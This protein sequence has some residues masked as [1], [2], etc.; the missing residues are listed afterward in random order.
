MAGGLRAERGEWSG[1]M[2]D[3]VWGLEDGWWSTEDRRWRVTDGVWG[4]EDH[5]EPGG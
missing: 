2:K 3:G 4:M 5:V 1:E